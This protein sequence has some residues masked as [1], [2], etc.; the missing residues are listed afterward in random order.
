[1]R[2]D[3]CICA[4]YRF[5]SRFDSAAAA[6]VTTAIPGTRRDAHGRCLREYK[7]SAQNHHQL[8]QRGDETPDFV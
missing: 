8:P 4:G 3:S 1:V 5:P 6:L 2:I 7:I